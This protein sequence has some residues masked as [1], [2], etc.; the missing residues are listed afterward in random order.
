MVISYN[1]EG[2]HTKCIEFYSPGY[3]QNI[4]CTELQPLLVGK[5]AIIKS[6]NFKCGKARN[7]K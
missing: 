5:I 4:D 1:H 7:K 2:A 3:K 6:M